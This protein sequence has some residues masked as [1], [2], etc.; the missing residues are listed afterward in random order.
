M[1]G[2]FHL[3][4]SPGIMDHPSS[5][6]KTIKQQLSGKYCATARLALRRGQILE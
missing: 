1:P 3:S 4:N 5:R 2:E 6:A